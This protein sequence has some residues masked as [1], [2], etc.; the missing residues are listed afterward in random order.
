M[1]YKPKIIDNKIAVFNKIIVNPYEKIDY[2]NI[3]NI[4]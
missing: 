3:S 4:R 1:S 2:G